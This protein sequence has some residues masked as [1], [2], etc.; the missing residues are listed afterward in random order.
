MS[1]IN[2]TFPVR[3]INLSDLPVTLYE[4]TKIGM[5]EDIDHI[6]IATVS[7]DTVK[8]ELPKKLKS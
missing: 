2:S 8:K 7:A 1:P 3:I 4:N 5:L 6:G